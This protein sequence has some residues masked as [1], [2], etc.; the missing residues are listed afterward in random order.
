MRGISPGCLVLNSFSRLYIS[1][2]EVCNNLECGQSFP[3]Q[4]LIIISEIMKNI[5]RETIRSFTNIS[6]LCYQLIVRLVFRCSG[7]RKFHRVVS[8]VVLALRKYS[9]IFKWGNFR[10]LYV[11]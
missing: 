7:D 2:L 11:S 9:L 3:A 10:V 4:S 6:R 5:S 1:S 8:Q